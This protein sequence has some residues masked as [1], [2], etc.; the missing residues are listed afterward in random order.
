MPADGIAP[1]ISVVVQG[2]AFALIAYLITVLEPKRR[3]EE[4]AE[5]EKRDATFER[6]IE[7]T[8]A[9]FDKRTDKTVTAI[10]EQTTDF[11]SALKD[12]CKAGDLQLKEC[13]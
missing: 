12:A 3:D 4:R 10:K 2:G 5:R 13:K 8:Y 9:E 6:I 11:R 7:R 1:W